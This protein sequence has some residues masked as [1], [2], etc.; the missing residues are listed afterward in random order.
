MSWFLINVVKLYGV[1]GVLSFAANFVW[2]SWHA[3]YLYVSHDGGVG[4]HF[5]TYR[6][7]VWLITYASLVDAVILTLIVI[8]GLFIWHKADWFLT[9]NR[10]Q[11]AFFIGLTVLSA[12]IIEF[13]AVFL[14]NQWQ[15][16]ELMPIIFGLGLSPLLQLAMTGLLVLGIMN[17]VRKEMR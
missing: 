14:F 8:G 12:V 3:V 9:M 17:I 10:S 7:F 13:K 6:G 16:S 2:E 5:Q 4:S 1:F 11:Y 15:Y